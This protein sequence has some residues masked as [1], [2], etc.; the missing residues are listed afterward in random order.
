VHDAVKAEI[1][2]RLVELK[3]LGKLLQKAAAKL[4]GRWHGY[5][6]IP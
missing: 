6:L 1:E 5:L 3:Q 4:F 2:V